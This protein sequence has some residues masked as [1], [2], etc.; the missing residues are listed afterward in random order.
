MGFEDLLVSQG[1]QILNE[2][3]DEIDSSLLKGICM[4]VAILI[5]LWFVLYFLTWLGLNG[6]GKRSLI[7]IGVW[8]F[9]EFAYFI[10]GGHKSKI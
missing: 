9:L 8:L 4:I 1:M 6:H 5:G 3:I 2:W 7:I 10:G